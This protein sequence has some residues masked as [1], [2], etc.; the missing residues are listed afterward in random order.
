MY[1]SQLVDDVARL[2]VL[3]HFYRDTA[4]LARPPLAEDWYASRERPRITEVEALLDRGRICMLRRASMT[5][6]S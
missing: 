1:A 2:N 6:P 5:E 4:M 3:Y